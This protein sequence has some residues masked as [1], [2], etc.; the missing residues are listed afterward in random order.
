MKEILI[1][2]IKPNPDQRLGFCN[3][4]NMKII[5]SVFEEKNCWSCSHFTEDKKFP[6]IACNDL[7]E[8]IKEVFD[9]KISSIK[10]LNICKA[11]K[12][13]VITYERKRT[14]DPNGH[15]LDHLPKF[16]NFIVKKRFYRKYNM[17]KKKLLLTKKFKKLR[18]RRLK[19]ANL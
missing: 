11:I 2:K 16:K 12:L 10:F 8:E 15:S 13:D 19:N 18:A 14:H 6:Y 9:L 17:L 3:Y 1:D 4:H 7:I 5:E